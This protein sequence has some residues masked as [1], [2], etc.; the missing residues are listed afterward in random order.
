MKSKENEIEVIEINTIDE[1]DNYLHEKVIQ[2]MKSRENGEEI[3][4]NKVKLSISPEI[5]KMGMENVHQIL[6]MKSIDR[7][8]NDPYVKNYPNDKTNVHDSVTFE[9]TILPI[10][11][12][13]ENITY[14]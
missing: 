5:Y 11:L 1:L 12:D 14:H 3:K 13:N 2:D 9:N 10:L 6:M 8:L 4:Q 7:A